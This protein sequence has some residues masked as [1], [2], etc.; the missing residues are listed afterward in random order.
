MHGSRR[1]P[2][3][4]ESK[5][6]LYQHEEIA[7]LARHVRARHA[8]Y[9]QPHSPLH[10]LFGISS[11]IARAPVPFRFTRAASNVPGALSTT[12]ERRRGYPATGQPL[13]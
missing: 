10:G 4:H 8:F 1:A 6:N 3:K 9:R 11:Q 2:Q 13:L 7:P 5:H 12:P